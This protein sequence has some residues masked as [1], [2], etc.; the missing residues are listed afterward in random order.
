MSEQ[1]Q[2]EIDKNYVAFEKLLPTMP[3]ERDGKF[4]LMQDGKVVDFFDTASD[5]YTAGQKLF[6]NG[7]FS[8]QEVTNIPVDLGFFSYAMS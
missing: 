4:A 1:L 3:K 8:I 5:A 7:L 6:T 2:Q